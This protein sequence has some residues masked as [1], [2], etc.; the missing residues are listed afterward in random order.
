MHF[1]GKP[2]Q[3]WQ[4]T[5]IT[6]DRLVLTFT[7][8]M[9]ELLE[10]NECHRQLYELEV[11]R[12]RAQ[13]VGNATTESAPRSKDSK[14]KTRPSMA[15]NDSRASR[16]SVKSRASRAS[17]LSNSSSKRPPKAI[18]M[19]PQGSRASYKESASPVAE[20]RSASG[21]SSAAKPRG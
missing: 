20:R 8:E 3:K 7:L 9:D 18:H 14:R 21:L 2:F 16:R 15:G 11:Q 17:K 6:E 19:T 12:N 5:I 10:I 4:V 1:L 13:R